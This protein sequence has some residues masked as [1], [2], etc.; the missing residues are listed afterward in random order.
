MRYYAIRFGGANSSVFPIVP[1]CD[2]PG[3]QFATVAYG[4][5]DP[6][7]LR[8]EMY[9]EQAFAHNPNINSFVRLWGVSVEQISQS[10]NLNGQTIDVFGGMYPGLPLANKQSVYRGRLVSGTI[11]A[12]FGNWQGTDISLDILLSGG[13]NNKP[14]G[15]DQGTPNLGGGIS[16]GALPSSSSRLSSRRT[17]RYSAFKSSTFPFSVRSSPIP[18]D[19][20][21]DVASVASGNLSGISNVL[22]DIAQT[23][24]GGGW[25]VT[26]ANLIHN[27][28]PNMP[29][30]SAIQQAL[31][32]AFPGSN[33]NINISSALKLAYQDSGFYQ[34]AQQAFGYW[35]N[36]SHSILGSSGYGGVVAWADGKNINVLDFSTQGVN[37]VIDLD[38]FDLIGQPTW[39]D[40]VTISIKMVMRSDIN[41]GDTVTLPSNTPVTISVP[42]DTVF[43]N[44]Q[45]GFLQSLTLGFT[46][47]FSVQTVLHVGDS[48]HPDGGQ[49]CTVIQCVTASSVTSNQIRAL[50]TAAAR[51][52]YDAPSN[53]PS[54]PAPSSRLFKRRL[55][56][57][58]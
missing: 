14:T 22:S 35:K 24:G 31:S 15:N 12:A 39:L 5:N 13:T 10:S 34:S 25:N 17:Q 51:E 53:V 7:A 32:T 48:R 26:P 1:G 47:S 46:G 58:A 8:C 27:L 28:L 55:R 29:L 2:V 23:F 19:I 16:Q 4:Q 45:G 44:T 56:R 21:G 11:Q 49:W 36:L 33:V 20:L 3:A 38:Y 37:K 54:T 57:Y 6:G 52:N 50:S 41:P 40:L 43:T 9:I 30:S 18:L 42:T